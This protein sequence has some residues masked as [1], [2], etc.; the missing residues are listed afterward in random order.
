MQDLPAIFGLDASG[1]IEAVGLHV[2]NLK[3]G[4]RV[5]VNPHL[6]CGTCAYCRR[7]RPDHC[8]SGALRGYFALQPDATLLN[9][10]P[11]GALAQYLISPAPKV[12]VLPDSIDFPTGARLGYIGTSFGAL[13]KGGLAPGKTLLVNGATGTLGV[14]A[15]AIALGFGAT[16]I[17]GIGRNKERLAKLGGLSPIKGRILSISTEDLDGDELVNYIKEQTEGAGV[18]VMFDCLGVGGKANTTETLFKSAVREGG[19]VVL[20]AGGAEGDISQSYWDFFGRD[21]AIL[22]QV[23]FTDPEAEEMIA[24]IGAG[25]IDFSFLEHQKFKLEE[26]NDA[27]SAASD[28]ARAGGFSNVV[29]MLDG[30]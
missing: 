11:I 3:A 14:A 18:D 21:V 22:G 26:V 28:G 25:V 23:W 1:T 19:K 24:M 17:I 30:Q 6:T 4:D 7:G 2:L 29:V 12:H 27:L 13:K 9:Q 5:Y 8:R 15:V 20:A 10:Y 16:K